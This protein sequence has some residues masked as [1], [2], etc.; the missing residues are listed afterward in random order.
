MRVVGKVT[1]LCAN[2]VAVIIGFIFINMGLIVYP[3]KMR[4]NLDALKGL[5]MSEGMMLQLG[6]KV[7]KQTAYD[8]V[9]EDSMK[10]IEE[11]VHFKQVLMK[12]TRVIQLLTEADID[13]ILDPRGY[14]GLAPQITRNIVALSRKERE[15]DCC[16][17]AL[18][19]A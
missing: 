15:R 14:A 18:L 5:M 4:G 8:I 17:E 16:H 13:H 10:T 1:T 3:E 12:D 6:G 9:Y 11:D 2:A 7:G 19:L